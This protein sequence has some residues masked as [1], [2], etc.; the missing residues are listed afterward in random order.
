MSGVVAVDYPTQPPYQ[1][2]TNQYVTAAQF[3]TDFPAF[4]NVSQFPDAQVQR[5]LDVSGCLINLNRWG[6]LATMGMELIT[7][8]FLTL[9]S[10]F[11]AKNAGMPYPPGMAT[12]IP[13]SKSVSKVSVGSDISSFMVD[14]G[15]PWNYTV[16]GQQYL[17]W[18]MLVGTGGYETLMLSY[19]G[20]ETGTV[21]TWARGVFETWG[22]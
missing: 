1:P 16:Y 2:Q 11:I 13:T 19:P 14:G 9:Q 15:G 10:Y 3:R 5:F 18:A 22:S 8:H 7:A 12:G 4:A 17:W 20:Q 6:C 21:M